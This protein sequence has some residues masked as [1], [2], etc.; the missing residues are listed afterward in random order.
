MLVRA[1]VRGR[2]IALR[3]ALGASRW[4]IFRGLLAESLVLA[5]LGG[6]SGVGLASALV[7][8]FTY[9]APAGMP[10]VD[11]VRL[12]LHAMGYALLLSI[13]SALAFGLLPASRLTRR[14]PQESLRNGGRSLSEG[15]RGV[16][17]RELLVGLEVGISVTLLIVAGLLIVSFVRL[18]A[19]DRGFETQNVLTA[20]ISLPATR[21]PDDATRRRFHTELVARLESSPG[22]NVAGTIS[23]LPLRGNAWTDVVTVEGD[24]RPI[25]ERPIV[26]YRPI[27]SHYFAAMGIPL[28]AGRFMEERDYPLKVAIVSERAAQRFWPGETPVGK[29]FRRGNPKQPPFEVIG[30][31]GDIRVESLHK[32]P[33]PIVYVSMWERAPATASIAIRTQSDPLAA[34]GTLRRS[35]WSIDPQLPVSEI[36]TMAQIESNT[37]A[38]RRFQLWLVAAFAAAALLLS[39]L[40]IYGVLAWSVTRRT[41]EIGI[42]MA[43]GAQHGAILNMV[44]RQGLW[45]IALG[46]V[47][48]LAGAFAFGQVL[49]GLLYGVSP[50]DGTTYAAVL[51][52]TLATAA[53]ACWIPARRAVRITPIEALRYE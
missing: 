10:R 20:E 33:E 31:V 50:R 49:S 13:L 30:V 17:L 42:R 27:S 16:R 2:E 23:V 18:D 39:A 35:V 53:V 21:Y 47:A 4:R 37:L 41:N 36:Q 1:S 22:V 3:A 19:V 28:R 7:R 11:D 24:T 44:L 48:G 5:F 32:N 46:L 6:A 8:V 40:G 25:L 34:A 12:D 51:G 52:V 15:S 9:V 26:P 43:L 45:P 14:D 29:R 38:Q